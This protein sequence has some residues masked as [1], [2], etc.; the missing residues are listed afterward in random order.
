MHADYNRRICNHSTE[1]G[2][3]AGSHGI[4]LDGKEHVVSQSIEGNPMQEE[5][6]AR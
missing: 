2:G 1:F 4:G 3:R 6:L 5:Q